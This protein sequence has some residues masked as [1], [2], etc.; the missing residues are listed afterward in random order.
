LPLPYVPEQ[1]VSN[2]SWSTQQM[3][4]SGC[5][6]QNVLFQQSIFCRSAFIFQHFS[7]VPLCLCFYCQLYNYHCDGVCVI[8]SNQALSHFKRN[9][10]TVLIYRALKLHFRYFPSRQHTKPP[11]PEWIT[12]PCGKLPDW[13]KCTQSPSFCLIKA[14]LYATVSVWVMCVSIVLGTFR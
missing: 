6:V 10:H 9:T 5:F 2:R 7:R 13:E 1:S 4:L 11:S 12:F 8:F 3:F 14:K